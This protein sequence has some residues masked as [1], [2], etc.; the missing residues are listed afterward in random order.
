MNCLCLVSSENERQTLINLDKREK[1]NHMFEVLVV[2]PLDIDMILPQILKPAV[3]LILCNEEFESNI[4]TLFKGSVIPIVLSEI[5]YL[6]S[7]VMGS[8][9]SGEF[10]IIVASAAAA[11]IRDIQHVLQLDFIVMT[12]QQDKEIDDLI[13]SKDGQ[14]TSLFLGNSRVGETCVQLNKNFIPIYPSFDDIQTAYHQAIE[15]LKQK[16]QTD[17][18]SNLL[19]NYY[20]FSH[21]KILIFDKNFKRVHTLNCE[22]ND[23]VTRIC[24][25]LVRKYALNHVF[26]AK[27][28]LKDHVYTIHSH[29]FDFENDLFYGVECRESVLTAPNNVAGLSLYSQANVKNDF[30]NVFY[31]EFQ[32]MEF[33]EKVINYSQSK[34]PVL[35]LGEPGIRKT[36]MAEFIYTHSHLFDHPFYII[37][38]KV[39][40]TNG[41]NLLFN[42]YESPL[43]HEGSTFYF[44]EVNLLRSIH[45]NYLK[46]FLLESSMIQTNKVL[47]SMTMTIETSKHDAFSSFLE[48]HME[49]L[50]IYLEP[51]RNRIQDIPNLLI[52]YLNQINMELHT[53]V[54]GASPNALLLLQ[55]YYWPENIKQF[56]RIVRKLAALTADLYIG[57]KDTER[58]LNEEFQYLENTVESIGYTYREGETLETQIRKI[59]ETALIKNNMNQ[60]K[61]AKLLGISRTTLWRILR[62]GK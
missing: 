38:C 59:A 24:E 28:T 55:N 54:I 50:P 62:E 46:Q 6:K 57:T 16:S 4:K 36:R 15:G 34:L 47:F 14:G 44:K 25:H 52:L 10:S 53:N 3:D 8:N 60:S 13:V 51:L 5:T 31:D 43:Y 35:I 39:I 12:Y 7:I 32:N 42:N 20:R 56:K 26:Q 49:T 18:I 9:Y 23:E 61:T 45:L 40:D 2:S 33:R 17:R 22:E 21:K 29:R 30:Y 27:R 58:I 37:D 41:W 48:N 1:H 19:E 11:M